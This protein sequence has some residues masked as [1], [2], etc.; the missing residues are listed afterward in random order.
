MTTVKR[1]SDQY[2]VAQ[3]VLIASSGVGISTFYKWESQFGMQRIMRTRK[4]PCTWLTHDEKLDIIAYAMEHPGEGYRRLTYMMIDEN[5]AF[6]SPST[7]YRVLKKENILNRYNNVKKTACKGSGF[8]QPDGVN[9]HWHTDI[10]YVKFHYSFLFLITV[11][12]GF[13]RYIVHHE[14]FPSMNTGDVIMT[15]Q[16]ALEKHPG[17]TPRVIT[18]NGTQF[19]SKEFGEY[20]RIVGMK[21]IRTSVAYPQ[22]NGKIERYHRSISQECLK[23]NSLLDYEDAKKQVAKYVEYYNSERLHSALHYLTPEDFLLGRIDQRIAE[24]KNKL[25]EAQLRRSERN[26]LAMIS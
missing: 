25:F 10:K 21:Q 16:R 17:A 20:L 5:V 2:K 14:L 23:V 3:L 15:V 12:D 4:P 26:I 19:V 6:A 8:Q 1:I 9:Q 22:S 24:R 18:D 11:I 7:V 13:S